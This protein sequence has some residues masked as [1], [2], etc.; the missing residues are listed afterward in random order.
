MCLLGY[1]LESS[2]F[3]YFVVAFTIIINFYKWHK[4][5][6]YFPE[7]EWCSI[8]GSVWSWVELIKFLLRVNHFH[9]Y[10][11]DVLILF[12]GYFYFFPPSKIVVLLENKLVKSLRVMRKAGNSEAEILICVY[13]FSTY[14]DSSNSILSNKWS[15]NFRFAIRNKIKDKQSQGKVINEFATMTQTFDKTMALD[16]L[17]KNN[18][19]LKNKSEYLK[20]IEEFMEFNGML[21]RVFAYDLYNMMF[22]CYFL[23]HIGYHKYV[24][25]YHIYYSLLYTSNGN[26]VN[27]FKEQSLEIL[28]EFISDKKEAIPFKGTQVEY[29]LKYDKFNI[30]LEQFCANERKFMT[31]TSEKKLDVSQYRE[32]LDTKMHLKREIKKELQIVEF[33]FPNASALKVKNFIV[34]RYVD[35]NEILS[36]RQLMNRILKEKSRKVKIF[37]FSLPASDRSKL[38]FLSDFMNNKGLITHYN[39]N[40]QKKVCVGEETSLR[41]RDLIPEAWQNEHEEKVMAMERV[42]SNCDHSSESYFMN[43]PNSNRCVEVSN[44]RVLPY[45]ELNSQVLFITEMRMDEHKEIRILS[46][47]AKRKMSSHFSKNQLP[48]K[49]GLLEDSDQNTFEE[50]ERMVEVFGKKFLVICVE[51]FQNFKTNN[52]LESEEQ[53]QVFEN[54]DTVLKFSIDLSDKNKQITTLEATKNKVNIIAEKKFYFIIPIWM[55]CIICIGMSVYFALSYNHNATVIRKGMNVQITT[56]RTFIDGV[57]F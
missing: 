18:S 57:N 20:S 43:I 16:D 41:V 54:L 55:M 21:D 39:K 5:I 31:I 9:F 1:F 27:T 22:L 4:I 2:I 49:Q 6:Y 15:N 45:C 51:E 44:L 12:L 52:L 3:M 29:I 30:Y 19:S 46:S 28:F 37:N 25:I 50:T 14:E 47:N 42:D 38:V 53:T 33:C 35:N 23:V 32:Y 7:A 24:H 56:Q 8:M 40:F 26:L 48:V 34:D 10:S 36:E 13:Y 11:I 17:I